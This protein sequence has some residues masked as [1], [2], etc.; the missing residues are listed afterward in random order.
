MWDN[1][2][3]GS[4]LVKFLN[5]SWFIILLE[6]SNWIQMVQLLWSHEMRR[7]SLHHYIRASSRLVMS[8]KRNLAQILLNMLLQL[9][10]VLTTTTD[11]VL[12]KRK[13]INKF[14]KTLFSITCWTSDFSAAKER[15][16]WWIG[17][18]S[19]PQL[20]TT[21]CSDIIWM[22]WQWIQ[23]KRYYLWSER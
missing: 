2:T 17:L 5:P 9:V 7:S 8:M 13:I 12:N 19:G 21:S 3:T 4:S 23:W 10:V 16:N 18:P 15:T 20:A 14:R 6:S 1:S 22:S 11:Y